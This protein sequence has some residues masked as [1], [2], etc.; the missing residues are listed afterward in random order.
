MNQRVLKFLAIFFIVVFILIDQ[1]RRVDL[2]SF[3]VDSSLEQRASL[4]GTSRSSERY[5]HLTEWDSYRQRRSQYFLSWYEN[6]KTDQLKPNADAQGPILDFVIAGFPKCGTTSMEANLG[7][8]APMP[9]ADVC[10]PAPQTVYYAYQNWPTEFPASNHNSTNATKILRGSKCPAF[11]HAMR[12]WSHYLPRT[13]IIVGIR[14]PLLWFQSFWNMQ[15]TNFP[16]VYR[17][18]YSLVSSNTP[19]GQK[20]GKPNFKDCPHNQLFC[21]CRSRFHV[22]LARLGKTNLTSEERLWLAPHD[23]DG[24]ANLQQDNL[25]NRIFLYEQTTLNDDEVWTTLAD[26]LQYDG[27]IPHDLV[28]T[29]RGRSQTPKLTNKINICDAQYDE[30]RKLFMP[31][32]Y[33]MSQWIC[34]YFVP[35]DI[36]VEHGHVVVANRDKFCSIVQN[37]QHD[38][39][40]RLV[41]LENGTYTLLHT[42]NSTFTTTTPTT[43]TTSVSM[44]VKNASTRRIL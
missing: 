34:N 4:N 7:Y 32:A 37:Y 25:Q 18:P 22:T 38:P 5:H 40:H 21:L 17:D 15:T 16:S 28:K 35:S 30:L 9:I 3:T 39:C 44:E 24:G 23:Y 8:L 43:T 20:S 12:E 41:R 2:V 42:N 13:K 11:I 14:H 19:C 6:N 36:N 26:Y 33:E 27:T 10:T 31:Y 29:T 1:H